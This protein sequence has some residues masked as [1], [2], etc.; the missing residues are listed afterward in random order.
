MSSRAQQNA[1]ESWRGQLLAAGRAARSGACPGPAGP[2]GPRTESPTSYEVNGGAGGAASSLPTLPPPDHLESFTSLGWPP[3]PSPALVF[4]QP[5]AR[6][7][8]NVILDGVYFLN[9][10]SLR[11]PRGP[12]N[13]DATQHITPARKTHKSEET[14]RRFY[15]AFGSIS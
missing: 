7:A 6:L 2:H 8:P 12:G 1:P 10:N 14:L 9:A 13:A 5:L 15:Y 3:N 4:E 11:P